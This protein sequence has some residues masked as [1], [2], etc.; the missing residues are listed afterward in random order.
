MSP[1]PRMRPRVVVRLEM[2]HGW[3]V[4]GSCGMHF[5]TFRSLTLASFRGMPMSLHEKLRLDLVDKQASWGEDGATW[6]DTDG[7]HLLVVVEG[8][9]SAAR[10]VDAHLA[11]KRI[12]ARAHVAHEGVPSPVA[13][14][15][16]AR[17]GIALVEPSPAPA[18]ASP[19]ASAP[20]SASALAPPPSPALVAPPI[21]PSDPMPWGEP[22]PD[23]EPPAAHVEPIELLAM[24]WIGEDAEQ[25]DLIAGGRT[26]RIAPPRPTLAADWGLPWPRPVPPADA[27][28]IQDPRIWRA[29]ERL[30]AVR[31]E[32]DK[33]GAPSFGAVKPEG[34]AWLKRMTEFGAP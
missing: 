2:R 25:H 12:G 7:L 34:S 8:P 1:R 5:G 15:T 27:L 28:A 21:G 29:P 24:P 26:T 19:S 33:V 30:M 31:E 20:A 18:P 6:S 23:V 16:A 22:A 10:L 3:S 32:L 11:A 17:F 4:D 9:L 13:L 14:R